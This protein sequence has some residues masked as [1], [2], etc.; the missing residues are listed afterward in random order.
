MFLRSYLSY[1]TD[2]SYCYLYL[3]YVLN[4]D[5]IPNICS[6][7]KNEEI[8]LFIYFIFS[9]ILNIEYIVK[10]KYS[11]RKTLCCLSPAVNRRKQEKKEFILADM[12]VNI[13][14]EN[15]PVIYVSMSM[16]VCCLACILKVNI[17]EWDIL[18]INVSTLQQ[19]QLVSK[20]ILRIFMKEWDIP[21]IIVITLRLLQ[22]HWKVIL[23]V[24]AK[25]WNIL[26]I[27]H[28]CEYAAISASQ[29]C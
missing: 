26:V 14:K 2:R 28:K 20:Y 15:I 29:R 8:L 7:F 10:V 21:V 4:I 25:M 19:Q 18:V 12:W 22:V 3:Y 23:S 24:N 1:F 6:Y 11:A 5:Y 17:K 16:W 13:R 27:N 9:C